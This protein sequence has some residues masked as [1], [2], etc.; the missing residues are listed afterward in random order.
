MDPAEIASDRRHPLGAIFA[1]G[2][3]R[4]PEELKHRLREYTLRD[5]VERLQ[6]RY[7]LARVCAA[8][9]LHLVG[10]ASCVPHLALALHDGEPLVRGLA[11]QAMWAIWSRT[12]DPRH[13]GLFRKA[14]LV[15]QEGYFDEAREILE[16]LMAARPEFTEAY[17]VRAALNFL[18]GE[19]DDSMADFMRVL[20]ANPYHFAALAGLGNCWL[21]KG[22][23]GQAV[24]CYQHALRINPN[25]PNIVQAVHRLL[26]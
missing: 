15:L 20:E 25:M 4:R 22:D 26:H 8:R 21:H 1:N 3:A 10:D 19:W 14:V 12:G 5:F 7:V 11:E 24:E 13:D 9:A 16:A 6:D 2:L 23:V 18:E 17:N